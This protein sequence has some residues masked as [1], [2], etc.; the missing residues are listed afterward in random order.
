MYGCREGGV[1]LQG[2]PRG[3][4]VPGSGLEVEACALAMPVCAPHLGAHLGIHTRVAHPGVVLLAV[5][6][7]AALPALGAVG[8][9]LA[10]NLR[11]RF[12]TLLPF[13]MFPLS[14]HAMRAFPAKFEGLAN[15]PH[16]A[17]FLFLFLLLPSVSLLIPLLPLSQPGS[18]LNLVLFLP[19]LILVLI[20]LNALTQS[21]R[22]VPGGYLA[23]CRL[24]PHLLL[25]EQGLGDGLLLPDLA[26]TA[27]AQV[28]PPI[29]RLR[30]TSCAGTPVTPS[31]PDLWPVS[32]PE[33]GVVVACDAGQRHHID[34]L[35]EDHLLL[36]LLEQ[37]GYLLVHHI[38]IHQVCECLA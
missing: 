25:L 35:S 37:P 6:T 24:L 14:A 22:N 34:H 27:L 16:L 9:E 7:V 17:P 23:T 21:G 18:L 10:A 20:L 5:V 30:E 1:L 8:Q 2:V 32:W 13:V 29:F 11:V 12:V 15:F 26:V 33:L 31:A 38:N 4:L 28:S 3:R 19:L 36:A